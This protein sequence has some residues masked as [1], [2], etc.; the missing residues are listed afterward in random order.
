MTPDD[1]IRDLRFRQVVARTFRAD[2]ALDAALFVESLMPDA[3]FQLGGN[4]PIQGRDNVKAMV[5]QTFA[6]FRSVRHTLRAV[7]EL[8]ATLIYEADVAYEFADGRRLTLPYA[9]I[10]GFDG[11]LV[12][13]YRIYIDLAPLAQA[14]H[15]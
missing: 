5:A 6:A 10:L 4:P 15:R 12:S 7:H 3:T 2:A 13:S 14:A 9:N 8:P 1:S 11:D